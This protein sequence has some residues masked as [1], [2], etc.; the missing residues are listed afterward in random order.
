MDKLI[1][2]QNFWKKIKLIPMLLFFL[3]GLVK[4]QGQNLVNPN[5]QNTSDIPQTN[6]QLFKYDIGNIFKGV[7]YSYTR[8]LHWKGQQWGTLGAIIG[9]TGALYLVD[10]QTSEFFRNRREDIPETIKD[11]GENYGSP[12]NIY[13][14]TGGVY[15]TGLFIKNEKLRRTGV[16]LIS[17]AT[18]T[19]VLQQ[20]AKSVVGRARP[21]S[22]KSKDTFDPFNSSRNYHSFP[23]GHAMMAFTT[24][25]VVAKQFK[26]IWVK[27]GIYAVGAIPGVSR[28]WDGQHWLSDVAFSMAISIFTVEA[29]DRYLN[30]R[31]D[32]K[33]NQQDKK[34]SW[35][36]NFT[37]R[38]LGVV[39]RF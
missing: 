24:A 37:P 32:K 2:G 31:Y 29:I 33:Y 28:L 38:Q 27:S 25:H 6:W 14:I 3:V 7:G 22:G 34:V 4:I 20:V 26:S 11:F 16:L 15:L 21:L 17:S 5:T 19:G 12:Q 30:G 23:S 18:A 1:L 10:D 9:G 36:L 35:N 13:M 8:P 39:V